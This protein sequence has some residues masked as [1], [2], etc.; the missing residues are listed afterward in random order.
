M[1]AGAGVL[2][3]QLMSL[4]SEM[5]MEWS[6]ALGRAERDEA[7]P[8]IGAVIPEAAVDTCLP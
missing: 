2:A 8:K 5:E 3:W 7:N 4:P 1:V 6:E